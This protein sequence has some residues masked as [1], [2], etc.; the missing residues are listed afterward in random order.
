MSA[1]ESD[2]RRTPRHHH[3]SQVRV[4]IDAREEGRPT[5]LHGSSRDLSLF[6]VLVRCEAEIP[7]GMRC[8]VEFLY[9]AGSIEPATVPATVRWASQAPTPS[10]HYDIGIEF[11]TGL[12]HLVPPSEL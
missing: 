10:P 2:K 5:L 6:G 9:S 8:T 4:S 11:A 3:F 12:E 7:V 1:I